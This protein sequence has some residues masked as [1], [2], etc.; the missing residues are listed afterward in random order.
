[1]TGDWTSVSKLKG[2]FIFALVTAYVIFIDIIY[3]YR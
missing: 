2:N 3:I 1:M